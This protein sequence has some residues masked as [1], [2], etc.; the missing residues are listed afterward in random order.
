MRLELDSTPEIVS[1]VGEDGQVN[2]T[3]RLWQGNLDGDPVQVVVTLMALPAGT[4]TRLHDRIL[5]GTKLPEK[6]SPGQ[7]FHLGDRFY[8]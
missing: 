3:G 5:K 1:M 4:D 7:L 8:L 2:Y 6:V